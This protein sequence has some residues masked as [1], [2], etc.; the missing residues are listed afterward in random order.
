MPFWDRKKPEVAPV[1][2]SLVLDRLLA[3][4]NP[5]NPFEIRRSPE[6]DLFIEQRIVD[7]QRYRAWLL[8]DETAKQGRFCEEITNKEVETEVEPESLS[9]GVKKTWGRG[10]TNYKSWGGEIG[11]GT[12]KKWSFDT[13]RVHDPVRNTLEGS[14][15]TFKRVITKS[16]ATYPR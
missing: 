2:K 14:G 4:N 8:L 9:F 16:A 1:A 15:W 5:S 13:K 11:G 7:E 3:L 6:T 10:P 12:T